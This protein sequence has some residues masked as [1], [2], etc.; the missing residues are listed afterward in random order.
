MFTSLFRA[1]V[2][3]IFVTGIWKICDNQI[4]QI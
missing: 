2:K 3:V 4:L 1:M